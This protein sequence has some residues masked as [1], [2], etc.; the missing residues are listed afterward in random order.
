MPSKIIAIFFALII[1]GCALAEKDKDEIFDVL[2][3]RGLAINKSDKKAFDFV[4]ADEYP[5]RAK[6]IQSFQLNT[7]Y[8]KDINYN[9]IDRKV[10]SYSLFTKK[11]DVEQTYDISFLMP[12]ETEPRQSKNVRELITLKKTDKGWRI[13]AGLK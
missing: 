7:L 10:I 6:I 1:S 5:D 3:I 12:A 8:F 2:D 13:I 4:V 11:A 9:L